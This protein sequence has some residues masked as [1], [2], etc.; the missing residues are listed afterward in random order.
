MTTD[1]DAMDRQIT[2]TC[3]PVL[4]WNSANDIGATFTFA[5]TNGVPDPM[6]GRVGSDG[7][8]NLTALPHDDSYSD[9]IDITIMLDTSRMV[10]Q[11]GNPVA[12]RWA[13]P[14]EFSGTGPVTG[15]GWFCGTDA[16]GNYSAAV[17]ITVPDMTFVRVSDSELVI[18]DDTPDDAPGYAYAMGLVLP[19]YGN[20]YITLDPRITTKTSVGTN[21]MLGE[22]SSC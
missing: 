10:D 5:Q 13:Q 14:G 17:P 19:N 20:Y 16:N 2:M 22:T 18:D 6:N 21:F 12:G 7:S 3:T 15:Y 9:N 11:N 1:T 8:I 4:V